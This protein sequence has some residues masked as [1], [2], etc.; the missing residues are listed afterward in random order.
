[1]NRRQFVIGACGTTVCLGVFS[2][3]LNGK[4]R[5]RCGKCGADF[6][7]FEETGLF[8]ASA[9]RNR[10]CPNCGV[11]LL[12]LSHEL[13]CREYYRCLTHNKPFCVGGQEGDSTCFQVPFVA[14][15][16]LIASGKP[17]LPMN[18]LKF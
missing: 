9:S 16:K 4:D 5:L 7:G 10:Y 1:M 11:N 14:D 6:S 2:L 8:P 12:T 13:T 18:S 17:Q 3:P 15:G